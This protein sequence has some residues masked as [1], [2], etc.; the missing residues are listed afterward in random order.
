MI[1]EGLFDFD[2]PAITTSNTATVSANVYDAGAA[3]RLF[4]GSGMEGMSFKGYVP[5]TAGTDALSVRVQLVGADIAALTTKPEVIA[6][7]GVQT[8]KKDGA[9][10]LAI[11][12]SVEFDLRPNMQRTPKRYYGL[13]VTLGGTNPSCTTTKV[14][15]AETAQTKD[16]NVTEV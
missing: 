4:A 10:V 1:K 7:S 5:I 6:D 9:T 15:F 16:V 12:D 13:M 2:V 8:H 14:A 3:E 11:G